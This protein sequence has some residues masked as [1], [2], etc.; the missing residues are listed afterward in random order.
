MNRFNMETVNPPRS[1]RLVQ[2]P[3]LMRPRMDAPHISDRLPETA[4][5][6]AGHAVMV[7]ALGG[8][9]NHFGVT[10]D[11]NWYCGY[12]FYVPERSWETTHLPIALAGDCAEFEFCMEGDPFPSERKLRE[13]LQAARTGKPADNDLEAA[14]E[15]LY[16]RNIGAAEEQ[17]FDRCRMFV[18]ATYDMLQ[19]P[20]VSR[21]V[22][23][24][25]AGL[26]RHGH[27]TADQVT[28]ICRGSERSNPRNRL[29]GKKVATGRYRSE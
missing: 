3:S 11:G 28:R 6:E 19:Q 27:L 18:E 22:Q 13:A 4:T 10:I 9:I 14:M 29:G 5:H 24:V 21:A 17:L 8:R 7:V 26:L 23:G 15:I 1:T 20:A 25:A 16:R 12:R 2:L